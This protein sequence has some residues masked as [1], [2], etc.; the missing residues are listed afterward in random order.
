M[1]ELMQKV[2][3]L[4]KEDPKCREAMRNCG[5]Y[6]D[7][8]ETID[9]QAY[10]NAAGNHLFDDHSEVFGITEVEGHQIRGMFQSSEERYIKPNLVEWGIL[11]SDV[12][13]F[14]REILHTFFNLGLY[15]AAEQ[16]KETIFKKFP[17][18]ENK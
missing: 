15:N 4:L 2:A 1:K 10:S 14:A 8:E 18:L 11:E 9:Y 16:I 12:K 17:D 5:G 6:R 7:A 3:K 13:I